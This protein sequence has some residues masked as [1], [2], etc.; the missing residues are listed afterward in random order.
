ME[1]EILSKIYFFEYI[2]PFYDGNGRTARFI[3]SY[4]LAEHL[5]YLTALRL[6]VI[7]KRQRKKYYD[8]NRDLTPFIYGFK[9]FLQV[10]YDDF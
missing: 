3:A 7:I 2:H 8:L 9:T 5:N 1:Y 10:E 4:F 6:S